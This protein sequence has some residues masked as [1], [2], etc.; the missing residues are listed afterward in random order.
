MICL[1]R[2]L[3]VF[4]FLSLFLFSLIYILIG[5]LYNKRMTVNVYN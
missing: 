2:D 4:L 5:L 3:V 1:F